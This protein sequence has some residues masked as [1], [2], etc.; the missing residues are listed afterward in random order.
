MAIILLFLWMPHFPLFLQLVITFFT[1][2]VICLYIKLTY[3]TI[4]VSRKVLQKQK[5]T[6]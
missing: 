3:E 4:F 6:Y 5:N 1:C 2:D